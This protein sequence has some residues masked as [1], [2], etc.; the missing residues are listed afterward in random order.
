M[1]QKENKVF[2]IVMAVIILFTVFLILFVHIFN[3]SELSE[4]PI[5][6]HM[7]CPDKN[8]S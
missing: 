8:K 4:Y 3:T 2:Y 6:N 7:T 5:L 1:G